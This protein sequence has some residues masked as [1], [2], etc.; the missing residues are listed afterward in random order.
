[1]AAKILQIIPYFGQWPEWFDLYL[2][3]CGRNEMIDFVY[4][5]DCPIPKE[6]YANT[7]FV[8]ISFDDYCALAGKRL[9][10]DYKIKQP[11]K[12]TD[13]K[14]FLGAVHEP[15]LRKYNFWGF[16][17]L[18]LCYGNLS[19]ILNEKFL[20]KYDLITTHCYHIAGHFTIMK[21]NEYYR[22]LCFK[23]IDWQTKLCD[24]KHYALDEGEWSNL[25]YP[26]LKFVRFIWDHLIKYIPKTNFFSFLNIANEVVANRQHFHEYLTSP[27]PKESDIWRYSLQNN[28][29]INN[30]GKEI[31]YLH[32]LFFKKT[33][34]LETEYYWKNDYYQLNNPND[35]NCINFSLYGIKGK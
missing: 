4:Y 8:Q 22:T 29:L 26:R 28:R 12:L 1:M 25:V 31:P 15:E 9:G 27:I 16:G 6:K 13:L 3:S 10:I 34:W 2:Y 18:D 33:P 11:Y 19:M 7:K 21:N 35:Y 30:K 5:T 32:F 24:S 17:D 23:I 20:K 14:P